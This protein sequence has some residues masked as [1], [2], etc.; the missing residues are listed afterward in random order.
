MRFIPTLRISTAYSDSVR[1]R[2]WG[3]GGASHPTLHQYR[4]KSYY[5]VFFFMSPDSTMM[6]RGCLVEGCWV[7]PAQPP[8]HLPVWTSCKLESCRPGAFIGPYRRV[9]ADQCSASNSTYNG[10]FG[11]KRQAFNSG[12]GFDFEP[13]RVRVC[14]RLA[15][16]SSAAAPGGHPCLP[17]LHPASS[18]PGPMPSLKP[19]CSCRWCVRIM[20]GVY[21]AT[22]RKTP[23]FQ[24]TTEP[25]CEIASSSKPHLAGYLVGWGVAGRRS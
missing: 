3:S 4:N 2:G 10:T 25:P 17:W 19:T 12:R 21:E 14:K 8:R 9:S 1:I 23:K 13:T 7:P 22:N 16:D 15:D 20:S 24:R 18:S 6:H 5:V 11:G